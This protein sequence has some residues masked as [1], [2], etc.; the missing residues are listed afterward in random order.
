MVPE[1]HVQWRSLDFG[2]L[3]SQRAAFVSIDAQNSILDEAGV[4]SAEAIWCGARSPGGSLFNALRLAAASRRAGLPRFWLRYDRFIGEKEPATELDRVQY[5]HW[6]RS[7][8][9]DRTRKGW[10]C[11]LVPE[12]KAILEPEDVT[13]VYPGWSIFTGTG[14][15]RWLTQLSVRTL[16]LSGYHTDWCV[17]MAARHARELGLIP[18][19]IGDACGS[20]QPLH[21]QTLEQIN[22]CYAP[23]LTTE[24]AVGYLEGRAPIRADRTVERSTV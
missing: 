13:L 12:A 1:L 11:E 7:Y 24:A 8:P 22:A 4:L 10:E 9:G 16:I 2:G 6:N 14:L 17:E 3:L 21:D 19:V 23:V 5:D 20:T 18:I 15:Q